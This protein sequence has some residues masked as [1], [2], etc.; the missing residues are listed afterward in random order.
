MNFIFLKYKK[1]YKILSIIIN[2]ILC[3]EN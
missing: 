1:E 3:H 2:L